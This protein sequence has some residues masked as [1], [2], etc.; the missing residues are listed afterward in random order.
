MLIA[1]LSTDE[2]NRHL[3]CRIAAACSATLRPLSLKDPPPD[4]RFDAVLYDLDSM[5]PASREEIVASA[6]AGP[7]TR[8]VAIH[9]YNL[10]TRTDALRKRGVVVSRQLGSGVL[11]DLVGRVLGLA[12]A[13]L[14]LLGPQG[15]LADPSIV[16]EITVSARGIARRAWRAV[17][18][19]GRG[20]VP[21]TPS[22]ILGPLRGWSL[23]T[24]GPLPGVR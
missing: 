22:V 23:R 16:L 17:R 3:A 8:L 10:D 24:S 12:P 13:T 2:V 4:G 20:M 14:P 1:Y 5:P 9:S 6:I 15:G 18:V 11:R 19:V 7:Q 21:T